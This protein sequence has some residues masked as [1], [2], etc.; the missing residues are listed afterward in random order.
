MLRDVSALVLDSDVHRDSSCLIRERKCA[1]GTRYSKTMNLNFF[2][3]RFS[4]WHRSSSCWL[5]EKVNYSVGAHLYFD[6]I[7][8]LSTFLTII[9]IF[10]TNTTTITL[11]MTT[12]T[13]SIILS[14]TTS[15][16]SV[17]PSIYDNHH[18]RTNT[19]IA[20]TCIFITTL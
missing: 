2:L 5:F 16:S 10:I 13:T 9:I 18:H 3:Y 19:N 1:Q 15:S 20:V 11:I 4:V 8:A 17:P 7:T 12:T 14:N 6:I